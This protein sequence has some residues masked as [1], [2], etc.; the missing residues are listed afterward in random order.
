MPDTTTRQASAGL[1]S[2]LQLVQNATSGFLVFLIALPLCLGI[3]TASGF[4]A[5]AGVL[6]AIVGGVI[7]S[8]VGSAPLTIKGPAAGLI[9]I[10]LG[11]VTELGGG[12]PALGYQKAL[13]VGVVAGAIQIVLA[14]TRAGVVAT[15]M[16]PA[17][18]HGMLAAIGV[19][20]IAK[21]TP[22]ALGAASKGGEPLEMLADIPH[23]I[24]GA[25]PIVAAVGLLALFTLITMNL[26][27]RFAI[28]KRVPAPLVVLL[29]TVPLGAVFHFS[30]QHDYTML[31][32]TFAIGPKNLVQLP[33][34]LLSAVTLPDFSAITSAV[35]IKYIIMF[36]LVG[37]VESLL[38]VLAVDA[39]D[40]K[41]RASNLDK[42]LL[43]VGVG[44]LIAS[45][46]G[47]LPMISEIV[48]SKANMD[49]GATNR[50]S[51]FF[52]GVFLLLFVALL[53]GLLQMIPLAA[54]AAMLLFTGYRLASPKE[55]LHMWHVGK[56]QFV[57]F[58]TTFAVT[59]ATDLLIGVGVGILLKL[60]L[61]A[62]RAGGARGLLANRPT[63]V[64]DGEVL[65]VTITGPAVFS[66]LI[67][68]R[69]AL[70]ALPEGVSTVELDLRGATLVDFTFQEKLAGI[71][72][73]WT[74]ARLK[75]I[76][77][78]QM[79]AA[80]DQPFAARTRAAA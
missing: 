51:N 63:V 47:G 26:A 70:S 38:S 37:S 57:V 58:F 8:F 40:P 46:I 68:L 59:L 19:I 69:K 10:A 29:L 72:D 27:S 14:L 11:A 6:T 50:F 18:V 30:Q 74:N 4:P 77:L 17:V 76:G 65:R 71:A 80:S 12:N 7:A 62:F 67:P 21:Q 2:G 41:K 36:A 16:P 75:I 3:S 56:D 20:I 54:L 22:V 13:A 44:N 43:A 73:E 60:A 15:I 64:R 32:Q 9:V 39:M 55:F 42:D 45:F 53:P 79:K 35:S 78:D 25:N 52:H 24:M 23:Y 66:T 49:A 33:G 34:S 48:R 5:V 1:R 61:H 31:G 28:V